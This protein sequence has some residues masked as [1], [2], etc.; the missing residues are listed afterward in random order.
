MVR[1]RSEKYRVLKSLSGI[2]GTEVYVHHG[3][4]TGVFRQ[5]TNALARTRHRPTVREL[6]A[7]YRELKEATRSIKHELAT[8]T[9]FD[10]RSILELV[11]VASIIAKQRIASLRDS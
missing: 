4:P 9:L 7:I 8:D 2:N 6:Q 5:L 3:R 11:S 10:T 1:V